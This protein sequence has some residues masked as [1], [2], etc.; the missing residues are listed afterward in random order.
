MV[1]E[2]NC[3][4]AKIGCSAQVIEVTQEYEDG[5]MD[6]TVEGRRAFEI[7]ELF[8]DKPCLEASARFLVDQ[9]DPKSVEAPAEILRAYDKCH[10]LLYGSTPDDI[11]REEHPS[12]A[13][14]IAE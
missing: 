14:A 9:P 6:I 10:E 13:Y 2:L 4:V 7:L 3:G 8:Q 5:R 1:L 12:M 11:D